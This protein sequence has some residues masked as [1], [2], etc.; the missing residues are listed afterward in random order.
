MRPVG[1]PLALI[2]LLGA[3]LGTAGSSV[4]ASAQPAKQ[5]V[6]QCDAVSNARVM[7]GRQN[8]SDPNDLTR[9]ETQRAQQKMTARLLSKGLSWSS[10]L[11]HSRARIDVRWHVINRSDGS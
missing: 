3:T 2:G 6:A 9:S 4:A 1:L 7:R 11:P 5:S 8:G 10:K